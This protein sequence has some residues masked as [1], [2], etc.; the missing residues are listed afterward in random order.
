M[1]FYWPLVIFVLL[2]ST[3]ISSAQEHWNYRGEGPDVWPELDPGCAGKFQSPINIKTSCTIPRSFTP[4]RL[5]P[6]YNVT[7]DF[8]FLNTGHGIRAVPLNAS[9]YPLTVSGGGLNGTYW[10]ANFHMHWGENYNSGSEHQM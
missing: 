6:G 5:S 10:L 4:F 8:L 1:H 7:Q 3:N 9:V 2:Y